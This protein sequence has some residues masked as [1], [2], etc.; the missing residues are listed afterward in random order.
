MPSCW[1]GA[2]E[3]FNEAARL[4]DQ[5][6]A[7]PILITT[8]G[9]ILAGIGRWRLALFEGKQEIHCIEYVLTEEE[10]LEFILTYH[11]PRSGWNAFVRTCLA[12]TLE[13]S[14]QQKA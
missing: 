2:I 9:T 14:L 13:P 10:S 3:E 4:K 7:E 1:T 11:Q 8:N 12:L 6:V 5:T